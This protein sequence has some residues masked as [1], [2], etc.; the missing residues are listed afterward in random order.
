MRSIFIFL[1]TL[2]T[3]LL[4]A[5][6]QSL[7]SDDSIGNRQLSTGWHSYTNTAFN[8]TIDVP[9]AAYIPNKSETGAQI[10]FGNIPFM[11]KGAKA[12]AYDV[13]LYGKRSS[14]CVP[15]LTGT[16]QVTSVPNANE[17]AE[18]G[19]VD[20]W[21]SLERN[22]WDPPYDPQNVVCTP[23]TKNVYAFCSEKDGKTV[24]ICINQMTD[25]PALA[26]E[27]FETFRWTK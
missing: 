16:S 9:I 13:L 26:K 3:F 25:N 21:K 7:S 14:P 22:G 15:S 11:G 10:F 23:A 2:F 12:D 8:Y 24:V 19:S 27:I 1:F 5:C 17:K 6:N 4:A 18:W 20:I